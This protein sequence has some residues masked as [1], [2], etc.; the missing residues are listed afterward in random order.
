MQTGH[1]LPRTLRLFPE[2]A[3]PGTRCAIQHLSA[4]PAT[5]R[6]GHVVRSDRVAS[7]RQAAAAFQQFG[8]APDV[9]TTERRRHACRS[10]LN[11]SL[12]LLCSQFLALAHNKKS[13]WKNQW[14]WKSP[15]WT[16][17]KY[18]KWSGAFVAR[19]QKKW[20]QLCQLLLNLCW[21]SACSLLLQH[22]LSKKKLFLSSLSRS[23]KSQPRANTNSLDWPGADS[24]RP[25]TLAARPRGAP[26]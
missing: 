12:P 10:L 22:V 23:W 2:T 17:S 24:P 15:I 18:S 16:S 6:L 21:P 9:T 7:A 8:Y 3:Y 26:C 20:R 14:L 1:T 4:H 13:L 11:L 19:P 5:R 25:F